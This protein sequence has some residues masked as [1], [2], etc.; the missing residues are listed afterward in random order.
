MFHGSVCPPGVHGM[1]PS[2]CWIDAMASTVSTSSAAVMMPSTSG[3]RWSRRAIRPGRFRY[4]VPASGHASA[5]S[6]RSRHL[7]RVDDQALAEDGV[8]RPVE[9]RHPPGLTD[10]LVGEEVVVLAHRPRAGV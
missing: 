4:G 6:P 5:A 3:M 9:P 8:E 10:D 7:L 2:A 1:L